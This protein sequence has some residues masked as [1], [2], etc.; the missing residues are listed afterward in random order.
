MLRDTMEAGAEQPETFDWFVGVDWG[1]VEHTVN[2]ANAAGRDEQEERIEHTTDGLM[3]FVDRLAKRAGGQLASVAVAIEVPRGAV[4]EVL[5][6]RGAAVFAVNPKQLDR[7]RDRFSVAGAKDDRLDAKVLRSA[8]QTDRQYF[9]RLAVDAPTVIRIRELRRA[10]DVL[11]QE[12]S[13][14]ASRLR[15]VVHRIAPAW[16]SLSTAADDPW[17]WALVALVATP[18]LGRGLRRKKIESLLK[19]YRIR[20]VTAAE[21]VTALEQPALPVA[22]GTV[23]AMTRH[24]QLLLPRLT[25]LYEQRQA[26]DRELDHA[27]DE[28]DTIDSVPSS[29]PPGTG[30]GPVDGG[31]VSPPPSDIALLRSLPGAGRMVVSSFIADATPLLQTRDYERLRAFTGTAPVRRQTGK[32]KSGTVGMRYACSPRLRNACYHFANTSIQRDETAKQYYAKLRARGHSH[33]RALRSVADR[34]LRILV[35]MLKSR[36]LYDPRRFATA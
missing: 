12:L 17:F 34:W 31:S 7:F 30:T 15:E 24:I 21:V 18:A 32:K 1:T 8:V 35:A 13:G 25:L 28:A 5:L 6:E 33:G 27:L 10:S 19:T 2:I 36:T 4:V 29:T 14:L 3:Q 26:C 16:L 23:E 9:R 11:Q 20:R 22:P